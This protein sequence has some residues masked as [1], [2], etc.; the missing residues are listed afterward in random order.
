MPDAGL[1]HDLTE[2][3]A[4]DEDDMPDARASDSDTEEEP[5]MCEDGMLADAEELGNAS[6]QVGDNSIREALQF[7][8]T[9]HMQHSLCRPLCPVL[10]R[11][12]N[13]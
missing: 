4:S 13:C 2:E 7:W 8:D 12:R 9:Q 5:F 11:H 6:S 10:V 3:N 1:L